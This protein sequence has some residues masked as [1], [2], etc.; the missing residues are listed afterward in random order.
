MTDFLWPDR[1]AHGESENE[2]EVFFML[3]HRLTKKGSALTIDLE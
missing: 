2:H 1:Y 3:R